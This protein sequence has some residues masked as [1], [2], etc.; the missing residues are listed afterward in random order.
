MLKRKKNRWLCIFSK[1]K[2][3]LKEE[4]LFYSLFIK[5]VGY[6]KKLKYIL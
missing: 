5:N 6:T 3:T 1:E 4:F 2:S